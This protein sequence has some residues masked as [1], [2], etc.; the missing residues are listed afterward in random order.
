M[1]IGIQ[2]A[3]N[4]QQA[5]N[6]IF[7]HNFKRYGNIMLNNFFSVYEVFMFRKKLGH[8]TLSINLRAYKS[9]QLT[10]AEAAVTNLLHFSTACV[11]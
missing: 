10:A 11:S 3:S 8:C 5:F 4:L 2:N 7:L 6:R 9:T 1:E